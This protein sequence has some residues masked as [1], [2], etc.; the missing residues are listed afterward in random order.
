MVRVEAPLGGVA[1]HDGPADSSDEGDGIDPGMQ[2]EALVLDGDETPAETGVGALEVCPDAPA[3]ILHR[4]G[5]QPGAAAVEGDG[6]GAFGAAEVRR[7][8]E[9]EDSEHRLEG[10]QDDQGF[11]EERDVA[12][13]RRQ[14]GPP[15]ARVAEK[16]MA[17]QPP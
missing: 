11:D 4:K 1:A 6:G 8:G 14:A 12:V 2:P 13:E 16:V 15:G 5:A 10:D 17:F 7:K 3:A 9:V